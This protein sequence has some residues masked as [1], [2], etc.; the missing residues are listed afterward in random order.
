MHLACRACHADIV[1][2]L[3]TFVREHKGPEVAK[4]YVNEVNDEGAGALHYAAQIRKEEVADPMSDKEVMKL[5][6]DEGADV[7]QAT[8]KVYFCSIQSLKYPNS[9]LIKVTTNKGNLIEKKKL[10]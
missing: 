7:T 10:I 4:L 1:R 5:L 8:N 6:L 2:H 9:F 3:I